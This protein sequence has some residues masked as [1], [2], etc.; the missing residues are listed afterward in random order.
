[1]SIVSSLDAISDAIDPRIVF[2]SV[3]LSTGKRWSER[4]LLP[5]FRAGVRGVRKLDW[6]LDLVSTG[7]IVK[8]K[9][10][11]LHCPDGRQAT[12]EITEKGTAFQFKTRSLHMIGASDSPLEH[13]VI[14]RV[15]DKATGRCEAFVWDYNPEPGTPNLIAYKSHIT[16]F[17]AWKPGMMPIGALAID[18]QGFSLA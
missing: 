4:Q 6:C 3:R 9:E 14:G 5:T 1:M 16:A 17:G 2:W 8:I 10:L 13:M 11:T 12:L 7:D 18:V 15:T